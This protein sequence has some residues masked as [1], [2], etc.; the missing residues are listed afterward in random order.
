MDI[1]HTTNVVMDI[2]LISSSHGSWINWSLAGPSWTFMLISWFTLVQMV[3]QMVELEYQL[4]VL[5]S[6]WWTI[7]IK[8][9]RVGRPLQAT[10]K[11]A[12]VV[13]KQA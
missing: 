6:T 2:Q 3:Y 11:S 12:I 13:Q 5:G 9:S 7:L 8:L 1:Q 4:V 10:K